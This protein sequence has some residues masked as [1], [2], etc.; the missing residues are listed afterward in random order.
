[1]LYLSEH[2]E[3]WKTISKLPTVSINLI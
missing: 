2:D 1:M 3:M